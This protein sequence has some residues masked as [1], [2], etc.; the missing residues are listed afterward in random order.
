[1]AMNKYS[2]CIFNNLR[3]PN[4][5]LLTYI[6]KDML[7]QATVVYCYPETTFVPET[8]AEKIANLRTEVNSLSESI[9]NLS[10]PTAQDRLS[11]IQRN[12]WAGSIIGSVVTIIFGT[13]F[14]SFLLPRLISHG[15]SDLDSKIDARIE[16]KIKNHKIDEISTSLDEL[17]GEFKQLQGD[18]N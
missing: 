1:M 9:R 4:Q 15:E 8:Q 7:S 17:K 3:E 16:Q 5:M 11:W 18:V 2:A 6:N 12:A 14:V 10:P 13:F